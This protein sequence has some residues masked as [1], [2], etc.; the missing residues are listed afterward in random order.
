M[1]RVQKL[2]LPP[3]R[4]AGIL[5]LKDLQWFTLMIWSLQLHFIDSNWI[6]I[7]QDNIWLEYKACA[8]TYAFNLISSAKFLRNK[9]KVGQGKHR[10]RLEVECY[11]LFEAISDL[12]ILTGTLNGTGM[13][14]S[15]LFTKSNRSYYGV[16]KLDLKA[17]LCIPQPRKLKGSADSV[18]KKF[19]FNFYIYIYIKQNFIPRV[20]LLVRIINLPT[21]HPVS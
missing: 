7:D 11:N 16:L 12:N 6:V 14:C 20:C 5:W 2:H 10:T 17:Y 1:I 3:L 9:F 13:L 15:N 18:M 8:W 19:I 4:L 21:K